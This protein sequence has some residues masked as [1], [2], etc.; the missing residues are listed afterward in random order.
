MD[1]DYQELIT[2]VSKQVAKTF[3]QHE[4]NLATRATLLDADIAKITRQIG[5]ETT[6]IVIEHVRDGLV[7]KNNRKDSSFK[8]VPL[9]T[10]T[11]F[12]DQ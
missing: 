3:L 11:V 9:F 6:K 8:I 1:K 10:S 5:L 7:K 4:D 2:K 12:S